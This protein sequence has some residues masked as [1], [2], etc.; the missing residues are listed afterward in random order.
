[1]G[2]GIA[3]KVAATQQPLLVNDVKA[4]PDVL[5]HPRPDL[6]NSFV[7]TPMT[8]SVPIKSAAQLLGVINLTN[9]TTP[10]PFT[11]EDMH[12]LECLAGQAAVAIERGRYIEELEEALERVEAT[13][14][15]LVSAERLKALGEM[16]AG[17]AH[18][19]NNIM[20]GILAPGG[21][22]P[23][24]VAGSRSRAGPVS[25]GA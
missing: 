3:G 11:E 15:Q 4:S 25:P 12:F 9:R 13:Q 20:N 19:F 10:E 7:C 1:M 6:S 14:K 5:E 24:E 16:A 8:V 18:D 22:A 17:V 23:E 2:T 21:A